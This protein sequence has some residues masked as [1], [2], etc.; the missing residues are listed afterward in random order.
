[1]KAI[2]AHVHNGQ[3]VL[4]EPV[5]LSEGTSVEVLLPDDDPT[6]EEWAEIEAEIEQSA[7]AFERGEFEDAHELLRRL[8][9]RS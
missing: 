3:I 2:R 4:D 1:V 6:A 5:E 8:E 7:A 9:A